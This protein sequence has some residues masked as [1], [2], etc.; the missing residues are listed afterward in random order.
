MSQHI[1]NKE[2]IQ[3]Q[4]G[5][6]LAL[7]V[8]LAMMAIFML[9]SKTSL[10]QRYYTLICYF[11]DISGLR[12]GAPVQLS[13]INVGFISAISFEER[14]VMTHA[15]E[16]AGTEESSEQPDEKN[17]TLI[18]VKV[19]M[20]IDAEY[21][22]RIRGDSVASVV[23]QGLL[24]DRMVYITVGSSVRK[25][26][27]DGDEI[28]EVR[29]P[30]GFTQLVEK[31]DALIIDAQDFISNTNKLVKNLNTVMDEVVDGDGL[32]HEVIFERSSTDTLLAVRD[33]FQNLERTTQNFASIS[34]KINNG[35]GTLGA[36]VNDESLFNDLKLLV[37]KANRNRLIRSI[38]RYTLQTK[39]NEQLK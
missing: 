15:E 24:G 2:Y 37:G 27:V 13:G 26:L 6:F 23:T 34:T 33:I 12:I 7:G 28:I 8:L 5:A 30:T 22:D 19:S 21:Q 29:N 32:V 14:L 31:G 17:K 10:F 1:K 3:V 38:I 18:K 9:S 25:K 35:Q 11:D 16:D 4:V 20:K 39:D 36:L